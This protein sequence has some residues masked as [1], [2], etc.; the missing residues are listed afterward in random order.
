MPSICR[1]TLKSCHLVGSGDMTFV[2]FLNSKNLE[3]VTANCHKLQVLESLFFTT[4]QGNLAYLLSNSTLAAQHLW[5]KKKILL[6]PKMCL[7]HEKLDPQSTYSKEFCC[8]K[9]HSRLFPETREIFWFLWILG[10]KSRQSISC[11]WF[12]S[13]F[14]PLCTLHWNIFLNTDINQDP[15]EPFVGMKVNNR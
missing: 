4:M 14:F 13:L 5:E 7:S 2:D 15:N 11:V 3:W 1:N 9:V 6:F 8:Q 12:P 10:N